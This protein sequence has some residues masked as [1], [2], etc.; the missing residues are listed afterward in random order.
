MHASFDLEMSE[1]A[2]YEL[3]ALL[4]NLLV[5]YLLTSYTDLYSF[6]LGKLRWESHFDILS[7]YL[8]QVG[9]PTDPGL[10]L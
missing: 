6:V 5:C 10:Q 4:W 2:H 9:R 3:C 7:R 8:Q 1:W